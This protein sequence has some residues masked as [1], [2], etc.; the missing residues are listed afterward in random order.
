MTKT[1]E[2]KIVDEIIKDIKNRRGLDY[3]WNQLSF[4]NKRSIMT[5]WRK[6]VKEAVDGSS[7]KLILDV[8]EPEELEAGLIGMNDVV[9][10]EVESGE[11]GGEPG[12][13]EEFI[14]DCLAQW[15]FDVKLRTTEK[16][17]A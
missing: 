5:A 12:E 14:T 16:R 17:G 7:K 3:I 2:K 15:Y 11:P 1:I 4:G 13:W 10:V 8:S 9:T 6:I